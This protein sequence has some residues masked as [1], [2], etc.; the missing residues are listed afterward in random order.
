MSIRLKRHAAT[1]AVVLLIG[2]SLLPAQ[3]PQQLAP[4]SRFV[5]FPTFRPKFRNDSE[6]FSFTANFY[7]VNASP[8]T[9]K[10]VTLRQAFP[11]EMKPQL[12]SEA[13]ESQLSHPPEFWHKFEDSTYVMYEPKLLRRQPATILASLSLQRRMS[14][15][16]IPPTEIEFTGPDGP[17]KDRTLPVTIDVTD[18]ANHVG[19]FDRFLRK[20]GGIGLDV[21]VS[22][23]DEWEFAP[24]DAVA[25]GK[26]PEGIIGVQTSDNGYSGTF[27]IH[28]GVPGEALD[29]LV[30]WKMTRKDDRLQDEKAVMSHLSEYLKYTGPFKFDPEATKVNRGK[31]KKYD[32]WILEG[33]WYDTIPK[34]L[35][36]GPVKALVFYSPRED[37][38]YYLILQAQ[39]RGAGPEKADTPAPE[40]DQSLMAI[41][42][43]ILNTFRSDIDPISYN[44]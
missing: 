14:T 16:E 9:I 6:T 44:R 33:R 27:R 32:A 28:N 34:H 2:T 17:G 42:E 4:T 23:R 30:V 40:K 7:I 22:G 19:D 13:I 15:F 12:V 31:F 21:K 25:T 37:V 11:A 18:Y 20:R 39:G 10:D 5:A 26:N 43:K 38:E 3:E 41:Q 1:L 8:Q 29:I 35:G 36:A 24:I